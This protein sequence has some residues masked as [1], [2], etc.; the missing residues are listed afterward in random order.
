MNHSEKSNVSIDLTI[1]ALCCINVII[2]QHF[3]TMYWREPTFNN[4][5][6]VGSYMLLCIAT[7]ALTGLQIRKKQG[8]AASIQRALGFVMFCIIFA[9]AYAMKD[10][11]SV[12]SKI[13][14]SEVAWVG[15]AFPIMVSFVFGTHALGA[16]LI[17]ATIRHVRTR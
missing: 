11:V 6:W 9:F 15:V 13:K 7:L 17:G 4:A 1:G 10:L 14:M 8:Q 12:P 5:L 3:I 16:H 2:I